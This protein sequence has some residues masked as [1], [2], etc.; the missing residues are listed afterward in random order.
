MMV[1]VKLDVNYYYY[2]NGGVVFNGLLI[3]RV[4]SFPEKVNRSKFSE[5]FQFF[6]LGKCGMVPIFP[7]KNI[8]F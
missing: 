3:H 5:F 7:K 4:R 1:L 6:F 2:I 8:N